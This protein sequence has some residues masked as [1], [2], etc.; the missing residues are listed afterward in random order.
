MHRYCL[1]R[2]RTR[3]SLGHVQGC[4]LKSAEFTRSGFSPAASRAE[5]RPG[6]KGQPPGHFAA[7][8]SPTPASVPLPDWTVT[9]PPVSF[10]GGSLHC[11]KSRTALT[12]PRL[13]NPLFVSSGANSE[14]HHGRLAPFHPRTHWKKSMVMANFPV[15][16][17]FLSTYH[18]V[19][20]LIGSPAIL[21]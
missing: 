15:D 12:G 18:P 8:H 2:L 9:G 1:L 13:P 5:Y 19:C 6:T 14:R 11:L 20:Y 10:R 3:K 7:Q 4:G 16:T 21:F 17:L